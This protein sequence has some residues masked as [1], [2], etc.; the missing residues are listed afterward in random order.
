MP[1]FRSVYRGYAIFISG[2]PL[3]W[4]SRT[5]PLTPDLPI[6]SFPAS[7]G[8]TS[9]GKALSKAKREVDRLLD[10]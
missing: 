8:H 1:A 4:A 10:E 9:W 5:E 6:V 2:L 7:G 3:R